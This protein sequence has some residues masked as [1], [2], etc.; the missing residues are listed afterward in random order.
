[1]HLAS[2][3]LQRTSFSMNGLELQNIEK[4]RELQG[5]LRT[6][7]GAPA[8]ESSGR[9]LNIDLWYFE[10]DKITYSSLG[11]KSASVDYAPRD[12]IDTQGL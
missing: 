5:S 4:Y 10:D 12:N 11:D 8:K 7:Y 6:K 1:M 2:T 9:F 3:G